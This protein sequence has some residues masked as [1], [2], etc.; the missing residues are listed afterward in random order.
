MPLFGDVITTSSDVSE[1]V[2]AW[3]DQYARSHE[4]EN[5][6]EDQERQAIHDLCA[7]MYENLS[8]LDQKSSALVSSNALTTGIL[9]ILAFTSSAV[10]IGIGRVS[11][12]CLALLTPSLISLVLSVSVINVYWSTTREITGQTGIADRARS[13]LRLRSSRTFRYRWAHLLHFGVLCSALLIMIVA[14]LMR[15]AK[16]AL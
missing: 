11:D 9:A 3:V 5:L 4:I 10:E 12:F 14:F 8:I 7:H 13:L 15:L 2:S 16:A 6:N 1:Y